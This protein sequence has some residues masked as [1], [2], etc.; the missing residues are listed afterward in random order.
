[1]EGGGGINKI[2]VLSADRRKRKRKNFHEAKGIHLLD[3]SFLTMCTSTFYQKGERRR[4]KGVLVA[5]KKFSISE[6]QL[7]PANVF[8]SKMCSPSNRARSGIGYLKGKAAKQPQPITPSCRWWPWSP[9]ISVV[10]ILKM[11][12]WERP[13]PLVSPTSSLFTSPH[14]VIYVIHAEF[15]SKMHLILGNFLPIPLH[16]SSS[17][18]ERKCPWAIQ[19]MSSFSINPPT[20]DLFIYNMYLPNYHHVIT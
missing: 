8:W 1:M 3:H 6:I 10:P 9:Q 11:S 20:K 2:M 16:Q 15:Q 14:S 18:L 19:Q 12:W 7:S 17:G 4:D 5:M 13:I